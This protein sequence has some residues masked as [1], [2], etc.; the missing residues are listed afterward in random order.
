M[1]AIGGTDGANLSLC[2]DLL[3]GGLSGASMLSEISNAN[4][5]LGA[6]A[7]VV[8]KFVVIDA[9]CVVPPEVLLGGVADARQMVAASPAIDPTVPI[10]LPGAHAA[11][12]LHT[13]R[14]QGFT[15]AP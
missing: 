1:Q 6:K 9:A 12:A 5:T 15:L 10:R 13:A 14:A 8:H 3:A 2:L 4:L 11:A 7:N